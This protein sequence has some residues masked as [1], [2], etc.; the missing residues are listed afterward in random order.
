MFVDYSPD[1]ARGKVHATREED[2]TGGG[3][4]YVHVR[5]LR[6]PQNT[7]HES[8]GTTARHQRSRTAGACEGVVSSK[9]RG[10]TEEVVSRHCVWTTDA[11]HR[12]V[13]AGN[14]QSGLGCSAS[15]VCAPVPTPATGLRAMGSEHTPRR[16]D[17]L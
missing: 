7:S 11:E 8:S 14:R 2:S 10:K 12:V 1:R 9:D 5:P 4:V 16:Q 6:G 3:R 13:R 15:L 17:Q